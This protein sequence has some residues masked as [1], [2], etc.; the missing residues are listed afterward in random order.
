MIDERELRTALR[1]A[2]PP[3]EDGARDRTWEVV[4]SAYAEREPVRRRRGWKPVAAAGVATAV[5][6]VGVAAASAPDSGVGRW[7]RDAFDAGERA[8]ARPA[9][10]AVP[11]GGRLLVE[12]GGAAWVV[13]RRRREA[14]AR[15]PTTARRGR[16]RAASPSPGAAAS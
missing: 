12:S 16:R 2:A 1:D 11:G 4:R 5:A 3:E 15:V 10:G 6:A 7:V 8:P 13:A 14:P 9:L